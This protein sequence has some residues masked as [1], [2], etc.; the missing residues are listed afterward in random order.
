MHI[1][2]TNNSDKEIY[3]VLKFTVVCH[4]IIVL[5]AVLQCCQWK[6]SCLSPS[7]KIVMLFSL[8]LCISYRICL[9]LVE[10]GLTESQPS[11]GALYYNM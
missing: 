8:V 4:I 5:L 11:L 10:R 2:E 3:I 9:W 1:E 6:G 7:M